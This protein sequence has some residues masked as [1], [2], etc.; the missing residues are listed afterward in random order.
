MKSGA[1]VQSLPF[2]PIA[3]VEDKVVPG[4][5]VESF[6]GPGGVAV[7]SAN[8]KTGSQ[9]YSNYNYTGNV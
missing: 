8:N 1:E 3:C 6:M 7:R 2:Y 5:N 9:Y 4:P